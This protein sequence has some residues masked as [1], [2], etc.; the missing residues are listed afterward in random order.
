MRAGGL[1]VEGGEGDLWA[2]GAGVEVECGFLVDGMGRGKE[3]VRVTWG[4][5]GGEVKGGEGGLWAWVSRRK[6]K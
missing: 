2:W 6:G 1:E 4:W 5:G 3:E